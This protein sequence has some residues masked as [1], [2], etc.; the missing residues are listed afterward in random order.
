[1]LPGDIGLVELK[2]I[3]ADILK[4]LKSKLGKLREQEIDRLIFDLRDNTG[5]VFMEVL[6]IAELFLPPKHVLLRTRSNT[7]KSK[8]KQDYVSSN[9]D[10]FDFKLAVVVNKKTASSYEVLVRKTI[11]EGVDP[12]E[13][14]LKY[15]VF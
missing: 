11:L 6:R 13:A 2:K 8:H 1:V 12:K 5:G 9:G 7:N 14:Y 15:G 3:T 10:P 4:E